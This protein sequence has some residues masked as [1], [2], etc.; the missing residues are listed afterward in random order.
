MK[1]SIFGL[2]LMGAVAAVCTAVLVASLRV[3]PQVAQSVE[4]APAE[5][6]EILIAAKAMPAMTV[7]DA[8]SVA[9]STVP[10]EHAP[11]GHLVNAVEVV[12]KLLSVPVV[13]GQVFTRACFATE[14]SGAHLASA[15]AEGMRAV[16]LSLSRSQV[17]LLYPGSVVDVLV[18]ITK[19]SA[20][21]ERRGE[22]ISLTLLQGVEVLA[23]E[24]RTVVSEQQENSSQNGGLSTDRNRMVTLMVNSTQAKALQLAVQY[25]NVSLAL[26]NPL[27]SDPVEID[28]TLLS[29]LSDEYSRLLAAL[30]PTLRT[31]GG[32][33]EPSEETTSGEAPENREVAAQ[34]VVDPVI[35]RRVWEMIIDRGE[36]KEVCRF[37]AWK[38]RG[39]NRGGRRGGYTTESLPADG[40]Q[41]DQTTAADVAERSGVEVASNTG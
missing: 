11:D 33:Q 4:K 17:G 12:G 10:V 20:S 26:R 40:P 7:V 19:P 9:M 3:T 28:T 30:A 8:K 6:I 29:E 35:V 27:D 1:W 41:N 39:G 2:L 34:V 25:G 32:S 14:A 31:E 38:D 18:S 37:P 21:G 23:I 24:N 15:L 22:A 13:E 5:E 16:S 36:G